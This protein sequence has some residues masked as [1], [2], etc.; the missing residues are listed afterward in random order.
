MGRQDHAGG[1]RGKRLWCSAL[2]PLVDCVFITQNT[3]FTNTGGE[4]TALRKLLNH[5]QL[6]Y[7]M[8]Q[9]DALH[10]DCILLPADQQNS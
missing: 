4:I 1:D 2:K 5:A 6:E 3:Y 10:E 9:A 8:V 7:V